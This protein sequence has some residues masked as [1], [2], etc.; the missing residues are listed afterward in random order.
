VR[1]NTYLQ[2]TAGARSKVLESSECRGKAERILLAVN[3][4]VFTEMENQSLD[5]NLLLTVIYCYI[6][7]A[8][9]KFVD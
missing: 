5:C 8:F 2:R 3:C 9:K 4:F 6:G 1:V 7:G